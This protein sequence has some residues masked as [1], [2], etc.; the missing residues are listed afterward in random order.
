[1][2]PAI[3]YFDFVSPFA[4]IGLHRLA[5]LP[6]GLGMPLRFPAAH[7]HPPRGR[8][9]KNMR[10]LQFIPQPEDCRAQLRASKPARLPSLD[11]LR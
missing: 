9:A 1:M 7:R 6:Q 5:E 2:R 3:W 10:L 11:L 4:Y 8:G